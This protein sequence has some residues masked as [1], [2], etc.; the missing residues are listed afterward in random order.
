MFIGHIDEREKKA[1]AAPG[2]Q[3]VIKQTVI[4]PGDGWQGWV[5]R[6]FTIRDKGCTPRH[7]HPWPHI[8]YVLQG[9][10]TCFFEG[11][12]YPL[13]TGSIAYVPSNAEHQ[14]T[15]VSDTEFV[16]LCIVPE[17]GDV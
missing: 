11:R 12:E 1:I 13:K 7:S 8:M 17:E 2:A 16:F 3:N 5:M 10:G 4:G 6:R 14:F 15:S 9:K